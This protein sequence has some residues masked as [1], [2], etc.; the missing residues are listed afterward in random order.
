MLFTFFLTEI[1]KA[2]RIYFDSYV[3]H[4]FSSFPQ[5]SN[6]RRVVSELHA[7]DTTVNLETFFQKIQFEKFNQSSLGTYELLIKDYKN[8]HA[9]SIHYGISF[10]L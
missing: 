5:K 1:S 6:T 8:F 2:I 7:I 9:A 4:F 10:V 3:F